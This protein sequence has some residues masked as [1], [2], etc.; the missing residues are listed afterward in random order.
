MA[1]TAATASAAGPDVKYKAPRT[2]NGHP[3]LQGVWGFTSGVPFQRPAA[4]ADRKFFTKE[5]FDKQRAA[6]WAGIMGIAR[7]APVEAV[8]VDWID[9]S[10]H[11]DDLRTSLIAYPENGR[12]PA[13]V[14]GVQR[15]PTVD[16][17]VALL[18]EAKGGTLPPGLLSLFAMFS[19][20]KRDS[21][22]NFTLSERC[23]SGAA[24]PLAPGLGENYVQIIQSRDQVALVMDESRR[25]VP[26]DPK[27]QLGE[28]LR[29]WDGASR[30]HWEGETLVIETGNFNNRTPSFAGAGNSHDKVVTERLT[31][32]S[33][34]T[35]QYEATLVD[36]KTFQSKVEI[37]FPMGHVDAHIYESACHEGNYSMANTLSAVRKEDA[38]K[39]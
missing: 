19:N 33:K 2:E 17:I 9:N 39:R 5:E 35:I 34:G 37:A 27:S 21:Y 14:D 23:L 4:F 1:V 25:I 22:E 30:G 36:P 6:M 28:K 20:V 18:G 26:L 8:A 31:R 38:A 10:L 24:V 3:D 29:K 7:F 12:L 32:T 16:E 15:M 11:V 13:L